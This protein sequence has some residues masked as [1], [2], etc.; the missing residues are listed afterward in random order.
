[1]PR[2]KNADAYKNSKGAISELAALAGISVAESPAKSA[3]LAMEQN[4][5]GKQANQVQILLDSKEF[6]DP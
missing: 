3:G 2:K 5:T 4:L 6:Q 1:M